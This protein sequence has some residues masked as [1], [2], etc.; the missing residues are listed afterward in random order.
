M[1]LRGAGSGAAPD[2]GRG[3][4]R[5]LVRLEFR[6]EPPLFLHHPMIFASQGVKL[7]KSA[8]HAGVC[9]LRNAGVRPEAVVGRAAAA[10]GLGPPDTPIPA[11]EV[12]RLF[13][14]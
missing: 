5:D 6:L 4:Q 9:A 10:V 1:R 12:H 11:P 7:S 14:G 13:G 3:W 8:G 2:S